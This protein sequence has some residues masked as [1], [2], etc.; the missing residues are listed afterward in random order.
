MFPIVAMWDDHE[1]ANDSWRDGAQNHQPETEG[2]WPE[3]KAAAM[4]AYREWLPVADAAWEDYE[5]GDLAT[6][7]RPETRL[8]GRSRQL[9]FGA[10]L[11]GQ[12]DRAAA[13]AAFRDGPWRDEE[14]SL[15][16]SEQEAWLAGALRRSTAR[17]ARWQV[18]AQQVVM[19]S[20]AMPPEAA[21]WLRPRFVARA[22]RRDRER[23]RRRPVPAC[24]SISTPGTAIRRRGG[25]CF[26]RRS[27]PT[28]TSIVLSGDSHNA[29]AFDLDLDGQAAGVEFAGHSVTSPGYESD[30]PGV[31]PAVVARA[32]VAR[33]PQL[34]WADTSRRGYVV[35]ELTPERARAEWLFL[36][37]VRRRSTT[38]AARHVMTTRWG[39]NR[40]S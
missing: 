5:I 9:G 37:T 23:P 31:D 1:S 34:R 26:A 19:G 2:P 17:G 3:R 24:R 16:G 13:L 12:S 8:T 32:V 29:W 6:L 27:T 4:R 22:A 15:M 35:V 14:R 33:N 25:G 39:S 7:F 30:L 20:I 28:P 11:R 18:L 21:G 40:L 36:D 38:M 10:V